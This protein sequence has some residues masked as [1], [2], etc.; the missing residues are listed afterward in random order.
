MGSQIVQFQGSTGGRLQGILEEPTAEAVAYAL[1]SHCFTCGKDL[2]STAVISRTL[3]RHGIATLRFD[4]TSVGQSEGRVQDATFDNF[5]R[6]LVLAARFLTGRARPPTLLIGHSLG[7][8]AVL[9]ASAEI[10]E[11]RAVATIATPAQTRLLADKLERL[12]PPAGYCSEPGEGQTTFAGKPVRF[13]ADLIQ[14]LKDTDLG[15]RIASLGKPLLI[16]HSPHDDVVPFDQA[17]LLFATATHP[18]SLVSL[19]FKDH[20]LLDP[21]EATYVA[22]LIATWARPYLA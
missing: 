21:T 17:L 10:P 13:H 2:K 22:D 20:L 16:L 14:G 12:L 19:T 9:A 1:Y 15:P 18:R 8:A 6:D 4:F 5:V 11:A 3:S 7:G